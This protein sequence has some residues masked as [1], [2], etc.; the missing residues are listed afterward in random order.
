[1]KGFLLVLLLIIIYRFVVRFVLPIVMVT[2]NANRAFRNMQDQM[3]QQQTT[4]NNTNHN[5]QTESH[6]KPQSGEYIEFE[7]VR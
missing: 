5:K 3:Q 4:T 7:E 2:R 1:M 6:R